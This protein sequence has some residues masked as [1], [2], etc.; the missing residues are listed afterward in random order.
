MPAVYLRLTDNWIELTV[1][2]I[3]PDHGTRKAKDAMS[4]EI[5]AKLNEAGIGIAST[6][7]ELCGTPTI[8]LLGQPAAEG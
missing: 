6:T 8:R 7:I 1:R 3:V 4:R 5:L 2:F